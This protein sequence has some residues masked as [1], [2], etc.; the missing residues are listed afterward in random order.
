MPSAA[1][2]R[3]LALIKGRKLKRTNAITAFLC[4]AVPGL[5]ANLFISASWQ[6]WVLGIAIGL[7]WANAFEYVYHRFLLHWP[8][9]SFGKGHLLHHRTV[10]MPEEPE[11]VTFG[12]SPIWVAV[13]FAVNGIPALL[14]DLALGW[15]IAPGILVGFSLYLVVVEEIH[16]RIHLGG[17]LPPGVRWAREYH[18]AHH[19]I[20]DGRFNVFFPIFD[21]VFGNIRPPMEQTQ[22]AEMAAALTASDR[23]GAGPLT[24]WVDAAVVWTWMTVVTIAIRYFWNAKASC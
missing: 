18:F 1:E 23:G 14:I 8:K 10:G 20:A 3:A 19:D 5:L 22:A 6:R 16:W 9:S 11:H 21:F 17:W 4:G 7:L 15:R 12:S 2:T 24:A 13:L